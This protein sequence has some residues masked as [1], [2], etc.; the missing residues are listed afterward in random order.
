[1]IR[2]I[3]FLSILI[4]VACS[5]GPGDEGFIP[6][7]QILRVEVEPDTVARGGFVTFTCVIKDSLSQEFN[8]RWHIVGVM[9]TLT[10]TNQLRIQANSINYKNYGIVSVWNINSPWNDIDKNFNYYVRQ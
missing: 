4:L 7:T 8:Y 5:N 10:Q 9:D 2:A 6:T 1:M 3:L